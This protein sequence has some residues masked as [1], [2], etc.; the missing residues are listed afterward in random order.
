MFYQNNVAYDFVDILNTTKT[1]T[2]YVENDDEIWELIRN[3]DEV[4]HIGN[5]RQQLCFANL[6]CYLNDVFPFLE[7]NYYVND[8]N[9]SFSIFTQPI[10]TIWDL[11]EI[12]YNYIIE[13]G[14]PECDSWMDSEFNFNWNDLSGD[15]DV[16]V[17]VYE[18]LTGNIAEDL[19]EIHQS[20]VENQKNNDDKY[21]LNYIRET[22][23]LEK[24]TK[25]IMKK[26]PNYTVGYSTNYS[27]P[28]TITIKDK[29]GNNV[30][31]N[32]ITI[33]LHSD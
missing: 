22:V 28:A 11:K 8:R 24:L 9:S 1:L 7:T 21:V 5:A 6:E 18:D 23:L 4:P 14:I 33:L 26:F 31:I 19:D 16:W 13:Y 20:Y 15:F 12:I 10:S 2:G 25:E 3:S 30:D 27:L 32:N 29:D 17:H